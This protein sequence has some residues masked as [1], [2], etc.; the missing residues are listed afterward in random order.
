MY[1]QC[2]FSCV[3]PPDEVIN[4]PGPNEEMKNRRKSQIPCSSCKWNENDVF[5]WFIFLCILILLF[6]VTGTR[7]L[8]G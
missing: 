7:W 3:K 5:K 2:G 4:A 8:G 6:S 1:I